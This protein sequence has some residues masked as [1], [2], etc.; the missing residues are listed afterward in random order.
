MDTNN[1]IDQA[2]SLPIEERLILVDILLHSINQPES[3]I[4]KKWAV[5]AQERLA[6]LRSGKVHGINGEEVFTKI[7]EKYNK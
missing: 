1:I 5:I 2:V 6:D 7:K 3:D 4:D